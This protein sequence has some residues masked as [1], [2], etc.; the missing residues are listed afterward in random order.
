M[1]GM[2]GI[3]FRAFGRKVA[4]RDK[5]LAT[6]FP[7]LLVLLLI[8]G[9]G[10]LVLHSTASTAAVGVESRVWAQVA[11]LSVGMALLLLAMLLDVRLW[12]RIAYPFY[13]L[14]L[15]LLL[16]VE[17]AGSQSMGAQRWL[18][19]AS[20]SFQPAEMMKIALVLALARYYHL[21]PVERIKRFSAMPMPLLLIAMPT[22]L[23]LRQPDLGTAVLLLLL[24]IGVLFLA[25]VRYRYFF[26]AGI[27][28]LC[29]LPL[30][31]QFLHAYQIKRIM[32][33]LWP[34]Q[35]PMGAGWHILQ[36][37]IALGSGGV[38]GRGYMSGSQNTLNFLP[39]KETDFIFTV[40]AEELGLMGSLTLM[41]MYLVAL[42]FVFL[43]ALRSGSHFGRILAMGLGVNFFL[44]A[45]ANI[46]MVTGLIP[47]VG[48]P[49]PLVSYGGSAVVALLFGFGLVMNVHVHQTIAPAAAPALR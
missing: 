14:A 19:F 29:S 6:H 32:T 24:G 21:L 39:E 41:L 42:L 9:V 30:I 49:L 1:I 43:V 33:F 22:L 4:L 3:L 13:G 45:F 12:L 31:W 44:H 36:S 11:R 20:V 5:L 17:F 34:E 35:D 27:L 2:I 38:F 25:G 15:L 37:K 7:L 26:T 47:V 8:G 48:M 28:G 18:R 23:L 16:L 40:L 46:A 10:V